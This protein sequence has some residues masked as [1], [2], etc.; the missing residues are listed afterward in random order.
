MPTKNNYALLIGIN[1]VGTSAQLNGC[2]NDVI[3][4]K[5]VMKT[6]YGYKEKNI[7][8]LMDRQG[9]ISPTATNIIQQLNSLYLKAKRGL[10]NEI[11]IHYSGH[12]TSIIDRNRDETDG[13]DECIVPLDYAKSGVITDDLIYSFLSKISPVKKITWIFDS[14]NSASCSDLPYSYTLNNS[15][16]IIKQVLS[17]R[18]PIANNKNIFVLSGCLDAKVSYDVRESDGT[19][20]GLLSYN[21]RKTLEQYGYSCTISQ[22]LTNIKK[23]FGSNDQ[24]PVLSVNSN[25]YGPNTI[26]FEK[27][28]LTQST[29]PVQ[30]QTQTQTQIKPTT[31]TINNINNTNNQIRNLYLQLNSFKYKCKN[32]RKEQ[33]NSNIDNFT[34]ELNDIK[35]KLNKNK[36]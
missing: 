30:T 23:E 13:R 28:I 24:T 31:I 32:M 17:K 12:G 5:E 8:T 34:D 2:Q 25:S 11:Y 1:Y 21:L 6:H 16:Q 3:K 27:S 33:F 10:V 36:I 35:E 4:M 14:C 15:N 18:R 20:C 22:L 19:P 26:I 7:I 29:K 9:F